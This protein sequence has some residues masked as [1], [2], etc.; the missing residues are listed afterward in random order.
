MD[1]ISHLSRAKAILLAVNYA[2]DSNISALQQL[3]APPASKLSLEL[4]LRVLLT[5]LPETVDPALYTPFLQHLTSKTPTQNPFLDFSA[6]EDVSEDEA[7]ERVRRLRLLPLRYSHTTLPVTADP[8]S[9]F[10]VHRAHRI[11][12]QTGLLALLPQLI[13]PFLEQSKDLK[14][15][16]ISKLLPVLRNNYEYYGQEPSGLVLA[17]LERLTGASGVNYLLACAKAKKNMHVGEFSHIARDLR[18]LVG[19]W[20]YGSIE[21]KRRKLG[22]DV[23]STESQSEIASQTKSDELSTI[24]QSD[25]DVSEWY[26]VF[27]WLVVTAREKPALV[28][29]AIEFWDG[30]RDVDLGSYEDSTSSM[31]P[32]TV[33]KLNWHYARAAI[34][35]IY[36]IPDASSGSLSGIGRVLSKIG[37]LLSHEPPLHLQASLSALPVIEADFT[38]LVSSPRNLLLSDIVLESKNPFL[39]PSDESFLFLHALWLSS[40]LLNGMDCHYSFKELADLCLFAGEDV[41]R[42]QS[43]KCVRNIS[44]RSRNDDDDWKQARKNILWL[45]GW[46]FE[47]QSHA[48]DQNFSVPGRGLFGRLKRSS[49]ETEVL[50]AILSGLHHRVIIETYLRKEGPLPLGQVEQAIVNVAMSFYDNASNCN[51]T[52]GGVKKAS[53][54]IKAFYPDYFPHSTALARAEILITATHALSF[55]ALTLQH[56]VPFRP[57]TIRVHQDPISLIG[58][59]LEQNPRSYLRLDDLLEIGRN[60]IQAGQIGLKSGSNMVDLSSTAEA[61]AIRN[62]ERRITGMAIEAALSEDDFGTAHD[63]VLNR[64]PIEVSAAA[65]DDVSW[66]AA[67][68]AGR[69]RPMHSLSRSTA[70]LSS[71]SNSDKRR[72]EMRMELLSHALLLAPP[73]A[74]SGILAAWRQC[75]GEMNR[76]IAQE[77]EEEE[78][79][80]EKD[81]RPTYDTRGRSSIPGLKRDPSVPEGVEEAP[82]GLFDVAR[83]AA[84]ALSKSAISTTS[85]ASSGVEG[86]VRKRDMVSNM[87]TGGLASGIGWVLGASPVQPGQG[88]E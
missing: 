68:Q 34:G 83:S 57:V 3:T 19:P 85:T 36:S 12:V 55:Y 27:E 66:R 18:G 51:R 13:V 63:Y 32:D 25:T 70:Q 76:L 24:D 56:D 11:D 73:A 16:F 71:P 7:R 15:W 62:T 69:Y 74:L 79:W 30:P 14:I 42:D 80:E 8:L 39:I 22:H 41:Q 4:P 65:K 50:R 17:D 23:S 47:E 44:N 87:V 31:S 46:G 28:F 26:N 77:A 29:D 60:L 5:F 61:E 48:S 58:K 37:S 72:L 88:Q 78:A 21:Q 53:D 9:A 84:V 10:L 64:L 43:K 82:M 1:T 40:S 35:V 86:R 54:I 2:I 20:V 6:V 52:R 49:L 45:W 33:R 67:F 75:E 38:A 81:D 59:V